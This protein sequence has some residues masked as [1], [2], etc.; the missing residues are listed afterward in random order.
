MIALAF[1]GILF[2]AQVREAPEMV[3]RGR[4][5]VKVQED[6]LQRSAN[7]LTPREAAGYDCVI[8]RIG[9]DYYWATRENRPLIRHEGPGYIT[10]VAPDGAG[11][12]KILRPEM[13][14]VVSKVK[15][16]EAAFDY[17]EHMPIGLSSITY[18]GSAQ[19]VR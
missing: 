1:S 10:Y 6:G 19:T 7:A 13:K 14:S 4:P 8:S 9:D 18:F 12:V 16:T 11:Y 17:V 15:A 3:F 2:L 5:G